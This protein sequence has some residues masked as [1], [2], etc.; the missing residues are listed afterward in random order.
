MARFA[1]ITVALLCIVC[2]LALCIAP[3]VDIPVTVLKSLQIA[4]L[5]IF[6][7]LAIPLLLVNFFLSRIVLLR[8]A[9]E[10]GRAVFTWPC[11]LSLE[12]NC[13]QRC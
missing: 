3:Y 8:H 6:L 4:L 9:L 10:D 5:L 11:S 13:V 12:R 2:V 1:K 7:L